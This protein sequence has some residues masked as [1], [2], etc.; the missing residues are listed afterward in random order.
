MTEKG[1]AQL[2][3]G[4]RRAKWL[5]RTWKSMLF[6]EDR[7]AFARHAK[8]RL[9]VALGNC[10]AK[11]RRDENSIPGEETTKGQPFRKLHLKKGLFTAALFGTIVLA[12]GS[13]Y[14]N[15]ILPKAY[16]IL[17]SEGPKATLE[18]FQNP[19]KTENLLGEGYAVL[20]SEG[21]EAAL[22]FFQNQRETFD[23]L[24][25]QA[26]AAFRNGD[27]L[28]AK[29][30]GTRVLKSEAIKDQA[31][32]SYLLGIVRTTEGDFN[33]A[34]KDLL[35][36]LSIY[37]VTGKALPLARTRLALAKLHLSQRD[38][39][40]AS[41]YANLAETT[42]DAWNDQ[43]FLYIKA[44]IAFLRNDFDEALRIVLKQEKVADGDNSQLAGVYAD[45]GFYSCLV[46]K[47][48]QCF[49]F[50]M[51]AQTLAQKL[52]SEKLLMYNQV[53]FYLYMKCTS[54]EASFYRETALEYARTTPDIKLM[55]YLYFVDKFTCPI[56]RPNPG[57]P[58]PPDD[59]KDP[60]DPLPNPLRHGDLSDDSTNQPKNSPTKRID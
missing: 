41:Y 19:G 11:K 42:Y 8:T 5:G 58:D 20:R 4:E 21:P 1:K 17:R 34:Q 10:L 44:Q 46:G 40:K 14:K 49:D 7:E 25:G 55:E 18:L 45:I 39:D 38:L 22:G 23:H 24:F 60:G 33:Q 36:A 57:D 52:N 31:R 59:P 13:L 3:P 27:Y 53:N 32:A 15:S 30:L 50:T 28:T 2:K 26:W 9:I 47:F 37:E 48:N 6:E 54:R 16:E 51:K 43:F 29:R 35:I 12:V 56:P